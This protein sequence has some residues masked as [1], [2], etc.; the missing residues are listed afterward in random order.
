MASSSPRPSSIYVSAHPI[1]KIVFTSIVGTLVY[2]A[3]KP[4]LVGCTT[5]FTDVTIPKWLALVIG[6]SIALNGYLLQNVASTVEGA[7]GPAS[8]APAAPA[9][10]KVEPSP[11]P[12]SILRTRSGSVPRFAE[13]EVTA[14]IPASFSRPASRALKLPLPP[15]AGFTIGLPSPMSSSQSGSDEEPSVPV[16]SAPAPAPQVVQVFV[17]ASSK[18]TN[19]KK[20][21]PARPLDELVPLLPSP[22]N[23]AALTKLVGTLTDEEMVTLVK[24]GKIAAYAL[25]KVLGGGIES[26]LPTEKRNEK[27]ERAVAIRRGV[28]CMFIIF[29]S[30]SPR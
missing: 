30:H 17:P 19:D 25:E 3:L 15:R 4:A 14:K 1:E 22:P 5:L 7:S 21:Q 18:S 23:A 27:L 12:P 20:E 2:H 16:K 9:E 11:L 26:D 8:P 10:T 28:L 29:T 13:P 24:S 6:T